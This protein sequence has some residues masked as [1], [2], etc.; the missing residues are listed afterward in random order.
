ME[1]L[2]PDP[3]QELQFDPEGGWGRFR[4]LPYKVRYAF[5]CPTGDNLNREQPGQYGLTSDLRL[6]GGGGQTLSIWIHSSVPR[7]FKGH[8]LFHEL[9]EGNLVY[10]QGFD[11]T[12]AHEL[13]VKAT[14]EYA[15]TFTPHLVEEFHHWQSSL[16]L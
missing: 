4:Q 16:K 13:A 9:F 5:N 12:I 15:Q 3:E 2:Q 7:D 14:K 1:E 8:V 10:G 11:V 6:D